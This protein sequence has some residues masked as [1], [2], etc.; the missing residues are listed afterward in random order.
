M[1]KKIDHIFQKIGEVI[2]ALCLFAMMTIVTVSVVCR[3]LNIQ[4]TA[5]DELARYV[6]IWSIYIGIIICTRQRAHVSVTILPDLLK[7]NAR[8]VLMIII[9]VIVIALLC[10]LFK[11][12]IDLV[13]HA[14]RSGQKAPITKIPYWFMYSSMVLGFGFSIIREVELFIQDYFIKK[15]KTPADLPQKKEVME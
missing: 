6:M 14:V 2:S 9:Q 15:P 1:I 3:W 4:F 13:A 12:S 7:G 11:L 5:A 8:K 10:W